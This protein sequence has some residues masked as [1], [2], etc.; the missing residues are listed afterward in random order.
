MQTDQWKRLSKHR[1]KSPKYV[2][3]GKMIKGPSHPRGKEIYQSSNRIFIYNETLENRSKYMS[4]ITN[5]RMVE[6]LLRSAI[7]ITTEENVID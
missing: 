4:I 2:R 1:K 7:K 3:I 6:A 5:I